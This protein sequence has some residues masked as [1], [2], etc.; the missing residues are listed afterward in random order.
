MSDVDLAAELLR[1]TPIHERRSEEQLRAWA[2]IALSYGD[3]LADRPDPDEEIEVVE[4]DG[5]LREGELLLAEY[6]KSTVTLYRDSLARVEKLAARKGW[7]VSR[8]GLR[9]AAVAHELVHH[10][11]DVRELNRRLG[12]TAARLG[13]LRIRGHVAGADEI[14]AHRFAH[15]RSGLGVSPLLLTTALRGD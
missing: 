9:R 5:G 12:H 11:L 6:Q 15:R 4:R 10:R 14:V 7:A 13:R 8:E 2:E 1:A 3:E